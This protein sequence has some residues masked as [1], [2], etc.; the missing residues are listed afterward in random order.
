VG[1][2]V[3]G[4]FAAQQV[5][6]FIKGDEKAVDAA[7]N[8]PQR[9][10]L[11]A[12][13]QATAEIEAADRAKPA[14]AQNTQQ[15]EPKPQPSVEQQNTVMEEFRTAPPPPKPEPLPT[16]EPGNDYVI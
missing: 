5:Q 7:V 2:A 1:A 3:L 6:S 14:A 12:Q 8:A 16:V 13:N 10:E 4:G 15:S 11:A 9:P